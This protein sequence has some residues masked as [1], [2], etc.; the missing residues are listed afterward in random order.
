MNDSPIRLFLG[1][2]TR[3]PLEYHVFLQSVMRYASRP[4]SVTPLFLNHLNGILT[5][6]RAPDQLTDFTYSRFLIPYLCQYQGWAIF[7]DA[8][9]MMLRDDIAKLWD[10]KDDNYSVLLVK[11]PEIQGKHSFMNKSIDAYKMFNWS[12]LMLFNNA[13]CSKLS[14]D[15]VNNASYHD[16]HQFKWLDDLNQIG[17]IPQRWNYLVGYHSP[18]TNVSLVHWTQGAPH[19]D[20]GNE[21]VEYEE[22]WKKIKNELIHTL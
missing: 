7:M 19:L 2:D 14:T 17:E 16:L 20:S 1:Y 5:R 11:H 9:D 18:S 15:Y 22:E 6:K 3:L 12:S 8:T 13:A 4:I 21:S 10:L